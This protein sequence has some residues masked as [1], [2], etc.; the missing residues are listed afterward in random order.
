LLWSHSGGGYS[1]PVVANGAV[2]SLSGD[3]KVYALSTRTGAK[4]SSYATGGGYLYSSPAVAKG[5]VYIGVDDS[6]YALNASTGGILP[7]WR[8]RP[9]TVAPPPK[10][11][12]SE[13]CR[14]MRQTKFRQ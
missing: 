13:T 10:T 2:Y 6:E 8:M 5:V 9:L 12:A 3:G 4:L 1:S 7:S 11:T 14:A